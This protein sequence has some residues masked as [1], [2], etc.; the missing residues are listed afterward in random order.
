[1]E[2]KFCIKEKWRGL[3]SGNERSLLF[4]WYTT[5]HP[6]YAHIKCAQY[7]KAT[8]L[9]ISDDIH[10]CVDEWNLFQQLGKVGSFHVFIFLAKS[11]SRVGQK[12]GLLPH[13]TR[14]RAN[15]FENLEFM[16]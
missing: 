6:R 7:M 11:D 13:G 5:L 14:I 8:W 9:N 16:F 4:L 2:L 10:E 12:L 1:M 15:S 3:I